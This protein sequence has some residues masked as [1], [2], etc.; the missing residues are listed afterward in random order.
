[1]PGKPSKW[2]YLRQ[3]RRCCYI[4]VIL[5]CLFLRIQRFN[6]ASGGPPL[7]LRNRIMMCAALRSFSSIVNATKSER[8]MPTDTKL[9]WNASIHTSNLIS[10]LSGHLCPAREL[11]TCQTETA[12]T[13][14]QSILRSNHIRR[15]G[16]GMFRAGFFFPR[17]ALL[18]KTSHAFETPAGHHSFILI[19]KLRRYRTRCKEA[20]L[21]PRRTYTGRG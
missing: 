16:R 1:M 3:N 6:A 21:V 12:L 9:S 20:Y 17:H 10:V 13:A 15:D 2:A 18:L 19:Q 14:G 4:Y 8:S 11:Q 7:P 5:F